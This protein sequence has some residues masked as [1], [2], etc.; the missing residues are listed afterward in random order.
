[1]WTVDVLLEKQDGISSGPREDVIENLAQKLPYI[2]KANNE[3][4]V[5]C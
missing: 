4:T 2:L 5:F 1:M 3:N